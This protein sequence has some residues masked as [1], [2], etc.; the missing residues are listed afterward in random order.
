MNGS[1]P[2]CVS[3]TQ[4]PCKPN[5][6]IYGAALLHMASMFIERRLFTCLVAMAASPQIGLRNDQYAAETMPC[7]QPSPSL[8]VHLAMVIITVQNDSSLGHGCF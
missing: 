2:R 1:V 8:T 7:G 3:C 5:K 4:T 6:S